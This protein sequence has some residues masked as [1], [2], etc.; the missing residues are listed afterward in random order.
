MTTQARLV[1]EKSSAV[2]MCGRAM[3]TIVMSRTTISW[4]D[5]IT[6]RAMPFP[7]PPFFGVAVCAGVVGL[8]VLMWRLGSFAG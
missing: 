5:A 4:Q 1:V 7:S 8:G 2:W 3:L 6:N